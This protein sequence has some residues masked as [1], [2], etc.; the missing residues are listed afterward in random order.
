M[1]IGC[2]FLG[3]NMDACGARRGE[4]LSV[5]GGAAIRLRCPI[6]SSGLRI[7]SILSTAA[8]AAPSLYLPLA[9][10]ELAT[11]CGTRQPRR[12]LKPTA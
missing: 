3:D 10:L 9:A 5:A 2:P 11:V 1:E 6:K 7:S 12:L 8:L 4:R